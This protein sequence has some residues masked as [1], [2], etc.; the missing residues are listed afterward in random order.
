MKEV[1]KM[2]MNTPNVRKFCTTDGLK[3]KL[4]SL[5]TAF[6]DAEDF[7]NR[8]YLKLKKNKFPRF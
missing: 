6:D 8:N 4:K 1:L 5:C 2:G 3:N 7:L